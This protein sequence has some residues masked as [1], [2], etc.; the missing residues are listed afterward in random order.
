MTDT[1][2]DRTTMGGSSLVVV[3][4]AVGTD[5]REVSPNCVVQAPVVLF[6]I[7]VGHTTAVFVFVITTPCTRLAAR[8]RQNKEPADNISTKSTE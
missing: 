6:H 5:V 4:T 3:S 2:V 7:S 8:E 1:E